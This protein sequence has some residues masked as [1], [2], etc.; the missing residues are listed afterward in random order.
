MEQ[1]QRNLDFKWFLDNQEVLFKKYPNKYLVIAECNV[2]GA[3]NTFEKA[4]EE[5]LS[6]KKAGEFLIQECVQNSVPIQY[7]NRAV[8]FK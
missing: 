4:M 1:E 3:Y 7:Y 5:A 2:L 6:K 8:F